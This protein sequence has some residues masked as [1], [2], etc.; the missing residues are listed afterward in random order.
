MPEILKK[1]IPLNLHTETE[2]KIYYFKNVI[3][4][5]KI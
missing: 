3:Q 2:E 1:Q 5:S 4:Q